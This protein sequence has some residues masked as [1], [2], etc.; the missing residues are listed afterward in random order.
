MTFWVHVEWSDAAMTC[1]RANQVETATST[2]LEKIYPT[3]L[4]CMQPLYKP[5]KTWGNHRLI[6]A[7]HRG[8]HLSIYTKRQNINNIIPTSFHQNLSIIPTFEFQASWRSSHTWQCRLELDDLT[9]HDSRF[10]AETLSLQIFQELLLLLEVPRKILRLLTT[11]LNQ[12]VINLEVR[13]SCNICFSSWVMGHH[14][15]WWMRSSALLERALA[16]TLLFNLCLFD[17]W[18]S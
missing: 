3:S 12:L 10:H 9:I 5:E 14:V 4:I 2:N 13:V 18:A 1:D 16:A 8:N 17:S 7:N 6:N 11:N 15:S